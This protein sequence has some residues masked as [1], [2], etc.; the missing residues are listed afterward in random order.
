MTNYQKAL[1]F[2]NALLEECDKAGFIAGIDRPTLKR[3][4][5][6]LD[7]LKT[8]ELY[9]LLQSTS[10]VELW[11]E[12]ELNLLHLID[13]EVDMQFWTP[14]TAELVQALSNLDMEKEVL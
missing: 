9:I 8:E 14:S 1:L 12:E 7:S 3:A 5:D 13:N 2:K 10:A 4:V 11:E 6:K